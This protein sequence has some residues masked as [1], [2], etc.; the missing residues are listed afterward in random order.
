MT[1]LTRRILP[2]DRW[3]RPVR[4]PVLWITSDA[5]VK[6]CG[7]RRGL[8]AASPRLRTHAHHAGRTGPVDRVLDGAGLPDRPADEHRGRG[9][10][11]QPRHV[12]ARAR[13]RAVARRLRRAV[14]AAGRLTLRRE[15]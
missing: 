6:P 11:A 12:P 3:W 14:G 1:L 9:G 13:A 10:N 7:W 5:P 4:P 15:P 8:R 2:P